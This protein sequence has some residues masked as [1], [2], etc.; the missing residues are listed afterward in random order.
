MGKHAC[1]GMFVHHAYNAIRQPFSSCILACRASGT[2]SVSI[3]PIHLLRY[4]QWQGSGD[5]RNLQGGQVVA[6]IVAEVLQ[7]QSQ[8]SVPISTGSSTSAMLKNNVLHLES[9]V[10]QAC[11]AHHKLESSKCDRVFTV[12]GDCGVEVPS[13]SYLNELWP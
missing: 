13:I 5:L 12:G 4:P 11:A 8:S 3:A 10:A 2:R 7:P 1:L 6:D 9:I